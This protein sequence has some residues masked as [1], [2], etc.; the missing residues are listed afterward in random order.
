MRR[1]VV[2]V[3]TLEAEVPPILALGRCSEVWG[4]FPDDLF[5]AFQAWGVARDEW[6]TAH[7]VELHDYPRIP[8]AL[9]DS[10]P[11]SLAR[12][13]AEHPDY[14]RRKLAEAGLPPD[15]IPTRIKS[16]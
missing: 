10:G 13:R 15:W 2:P 1:R 4:R 16:K 11:F 6:L 3:L 12:L 9:R 8:S 7:G 14:A 5:G